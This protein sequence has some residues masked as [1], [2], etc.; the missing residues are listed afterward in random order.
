MY[1]GFDRSP[2]GS[3]LA[4]IL[5]NVVHIWEVETEREVLA[6]VHEEKVLRAAFDSTLTKLATISSDNI[7]IW[8][9]KSGCQS[10]KLAGRADRETVLTFSPDG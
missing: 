4:C 9:L 10:L 5:H 6:L 2:D 3:K 1:L 7:Y 8:D